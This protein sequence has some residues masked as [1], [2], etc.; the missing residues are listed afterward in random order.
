[1]LF[2]NRGFGR[3][4]PV[5]HQYKPYM[6]ALFPA[7]YRVREERHRQ[8]HGLTSPH[9]AVPSIPRHNCVRSW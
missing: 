4:E 1:M 3:K 9:P 7:G 2:N 8:K 5:A 6:N